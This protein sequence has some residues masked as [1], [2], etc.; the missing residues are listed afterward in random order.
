MLSP[1]DIDGMRF[2][3][4]RLKEGYDQEEVDSFL[5]QVQDAYRVAL[6]QIARLEEENRTLRRINDSMK[7]DASAT[8]AVLATKP[9]P[10]SAVAQ[11]LIEA[12]DEA[13]KRHEAEARTKADD[14]VRKA[15]AD[16]AKLVEEAT[17]AA[18]R[19]KSEGLAEKYRRAEELENKAKLL[20]K[21]ISDLNYRG[22]Q[23]RR[24]LRAALGSYDKEITL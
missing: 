24:A 19:I 22:E 16:A 15:G 7:S 1:A 4:T 8:T 20:E 5:D 14:I 10:P 13:A 2:S 12:A 23:V 17:D 18:E 9:E 11:K 21:D 6:A 3:T